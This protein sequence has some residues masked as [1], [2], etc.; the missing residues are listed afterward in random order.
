MP[1]CHILSEHCVPTS[2]NTK[3][4]KALHLAIYSPEH[5]VQDHQGSKHK[6]H[7]GSELSHSKLI[8]K[9]KT[10]YKYK[11]YITK[12][13]LLE[14]NSCYFT[15]RL[16]RFHNICILN[17][18]NTISLNQSIQ[19]NTQALCSRYTK[20]QSYMQCGTMSVKNLVGRLGVHDKTNHTLSSQVTLTR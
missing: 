1:R 12:Y 6:Q 19:N 3:F 9:N 7:T 10:T 13:N 17:S 20:T 11:Y 5:K 2:F 18:Q 15:S 14:R 16:I 8:E 4:L